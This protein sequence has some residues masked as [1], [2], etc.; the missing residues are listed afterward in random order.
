MQIRGRTL[1]FATAS[2]VMDRRAS[3]FG[4]AALFAGAHQTDRYASQLARWTCRVL[5]KPQPSQLQQRLPGLSFL[6]VRVTVRLT[7][8]ADGAGASAGPPALWSDGAGEGKRPAAALSPTRPM[9]GSPRAS[10]P[11]VPSCSCSIG[12]VALRHYRQ[13]VGRVIPL[14]DIRLVPLSPDRI[15]DCSGTGAGLLPDRARPF[16]FAGRGV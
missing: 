2:L 10:S 5:N 7:L 4:T 8:S 3:A 9:S 15:A 1:S 12:D 14:P 16:R 11:A 13:P 6:P